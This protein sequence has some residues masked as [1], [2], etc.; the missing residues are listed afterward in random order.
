MMNL[1]MGNGANPDDN[2]FYGVTIGI[3]S[4]NKDP[5]KLGRVRVRFPWLGTRDESNWARVVS[6]MAGQGRGLYFLPEINDEVLVAFEHGDIQSPYILGALWNGVDKP[7]L[8]NS[9]G[10]NNQ[11][12]IKSRSGHQIIL[13]DSEGGEKIIIRDKTNKN[14]IVIDSNTN[15]MTVKAEQDLTIEV[16]GKLTLKS[17]KGE[18]AIACSKL[19]I[20]TQQSCEIN[21]RGTGNITAQAPLK[22][23]G[24]PV[25]INDPALEIM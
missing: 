8:T 2:R 6:L 24:N 23:K 7:P 19:S 20:T 1:L 16:G 5:E 25:T 13:D 4:N 11:R 22:L 17:E 10:K 3:V 12:L 21:S 14:E 9:D 18:V 15:T